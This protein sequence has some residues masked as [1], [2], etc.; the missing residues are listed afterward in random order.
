MVGGWVG[1]WPRPGA[2]LDG[3]SGRSV[4]PDNGSSVKCQSPVSSPNSIENRVANPA[5]ATA[6]GVAVLSAN[7]RNSPAFGNTSRYASKSAGLALFMIKRRPVD[8][9][10][11]S[12]PHA[13]RR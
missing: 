11:A 7:R 12:P 3:A 10:T 6:F 13:R 1:E 8:A 9:A 2:A 4:R 5:A